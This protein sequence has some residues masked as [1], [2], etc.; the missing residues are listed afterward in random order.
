M[1]SAVRA[2]RCFRRKSQ[3]CGGVSETVELLRRVRPLTMK[4]VAAL[5]RTLIMGSE[6][7]KWVAAWLC[8]RRGGGTWL[9][10]TV[11]VRHGF[12]Y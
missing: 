8:S 6:D 7:R 11:A 3:L 12:S 10:K 5:E 4:S 1:R 2:S 9:E